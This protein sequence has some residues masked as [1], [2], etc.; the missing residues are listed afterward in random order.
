ML[1]E[2]LKDTVYGLSIFIGSIIALHTAV[3]IAVRAAVSGYDSA[4]NNTKDTGG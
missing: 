3:F 1:I 4:K 2:I